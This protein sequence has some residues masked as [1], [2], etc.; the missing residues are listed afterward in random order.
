MDS[1]RERRGRGLYHARASMICLQRIAMAQCQCQFKLAMGPEW[2]Q[3]I[4][5][6]TKTSKTS[7]NSRDDRRCAAIKKAPGIH[8]HAGADIPVLRR[9]RGR[10]A[11]T[12]THTHARTHTHTHK[13][14]RHSKRRVQQGGHQQG[15][16]T[17]PL[18]TLWAGS[19]WSAWWLQV[20]ACCLNTMT[21][22][23]VKRRG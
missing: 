19:A 7:K 8:P 16:I 12:H 23:R 10:H 5:D 3:R 1:L 18:W 20:L 14:R 22:M 2:G 21:M 4:E 11:H 15:I 9:G 13:S 17:F 6:S